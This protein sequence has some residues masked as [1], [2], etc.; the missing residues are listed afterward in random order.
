MPLTL[1]QALTKV[2]RLTT[3]A[4]PRALH[5]SPLATCYL[6]RGNTLESRCAHPNPILTLTLTPHH[7]LCTIHHL[8]PAAYYVLLPTC[9]LLRGFTLARPSRC[10]HL[11]PIRTLTLTH[12]DTTHGQGGP[13]EALRRDRGGR[14][15]RW[16]GG[17]GSCW[18]GRGGR[19]GRGGQR[20]YRGAE[21]ARHC[22]HSLALGV[23][24]HCLKGRSF[25]RPLNLRSVGPV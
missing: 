24:R 23:T 17:W 15:G 14:G 4:L 12:S 20:C 19:G 5:H 25:S 2:G 8:L 16:R 1:T 11:D 9:Y 22:R 10:A 6:L 18:G 3:A 7:V 21:R 13:E